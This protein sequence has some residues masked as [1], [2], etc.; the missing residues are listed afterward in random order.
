[1]KKTMILAVV[2]L[3]AFVSCNKIET[4]SNDAKKVE[5]SFV[6]MTGSVATRGYSTATRFSEENLGPAGEIGSGIPRD[7]QISAYLYPQN[8]EPENYFVNNTYKAGD[9]SRYHNFVGTTLTP[10]YWPLGGKM[11]FLA[12]SLTSD[13]VNVDAAWNE[14]NA[15]SQVVLN[16]PAENTQN[17]ILFAS[18]SGLSLIG[19]GEP[20]SMIFKHA[21][22]WLTFNLKGDTAYGKTVVKINRI[23]LEDVYN[24][25]ELTISN[26]AGDALAEWDFSAVSRKNINVDNIYNITTINP[27]KPSSFNMLIPQQ[28]KT[29]FVIYYS[30][31][32]DPA[33]E[34]SYRF[35]TDKKTWLMGEHYTY[36]INIK[37]N[38]VTVQPSV[39][40]WELVP[41]HTNPII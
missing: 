41:D 2:A 32:N 8:G 3:A 35:T 40:P 28:K 27:T 34:L 25:G 16:V 5:L 14:G 23:V 29:S 1:M 4:P 33:Q 24:A 17:D 22:A 38:E 26:N 36:N 30:F 13:A 10:V 37:V 20:V 7:M 21:Q 18:R 9:D 39:T 6:P 15:A 11:D 19:P 12:Y 31:L